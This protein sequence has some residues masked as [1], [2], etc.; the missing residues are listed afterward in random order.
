[1]EQIRSIYYVNIFINLLK[2]LLIHPLFRSISLYD[3]NENHVKEIILQQMIS[4]IV[5]NKRIFLKDLG[6]IFITLLVS[7]LPISY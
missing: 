2:R 7:T 4:I 5:V 6:C 3:N 1:M